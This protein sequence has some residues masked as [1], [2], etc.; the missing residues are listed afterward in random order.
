[1][2]N[3]DGVCVAAAN[4][5]APTTIGYYDAPVK[6]EGNCASDR[7]MYS[8]DC[9]NQLDCMA[10]CGTPLPFLIHGYPQVPKKCSEMKCAPSCVCMQ[11]YVRNTKGQCVERSE[12]DHTEPFT[13]VTTT[14]PALSQSALQVTR[15]TRIT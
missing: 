12:C 6:T 2:K 3:A 14:T 13:T 5:E 9:G 1:L 15:S 10:T 4:C 8:T 11:P 7:E